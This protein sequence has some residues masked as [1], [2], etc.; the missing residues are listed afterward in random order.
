MPRSMRSNTSVLTCSLFPFRSHFKPAMAL[1][2]ASHISPLTSDHQAPMQTAGPDSNLCTPVSAGL[3]V[4]QVFGGAWAVT[5]VQKQLNASQRRGAG[6]PRRTPVKPARVAQELVCERT[7]SVSSSITLPFSFIF[8][9]FL[10]RLVSRGPEVFVLSVVLGSACC[11]CPH[12]AAS[13]LIRQWSD[14][15]SGRVVC[16]QHPYST[17]PSPNPPQ[18]HH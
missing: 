12:T 18:R 14:R 13:A 2:S 16:F 8:P 15:E 10:A 4:L 6:S 7:R 3:K 11:L 1:L 9:Q 5:R 17:V